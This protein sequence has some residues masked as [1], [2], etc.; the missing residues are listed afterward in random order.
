LKRGK[1]SDRGPD[2][3]RSRQRTGIGFAFWRRGREIK[4]RFRYRPAPPYL[5]ELEMIP[6]EEGEQ[7]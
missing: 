2:A 4:R 6:D 3:G 1:A 7:E 5:H